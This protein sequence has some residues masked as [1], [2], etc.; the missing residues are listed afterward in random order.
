MRS[1]CPAPQSDAR[2]IGVVEPRYRQ[3]RDELDE[4]ERRVRTYRAEQIRLQRSPRVPEREGSHD[5]LL[6]SV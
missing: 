1:I 6:G 5:R 2:G 4:Y 3:H